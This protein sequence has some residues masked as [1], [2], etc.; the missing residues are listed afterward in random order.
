MVGVFD[1]IPR[2]DRFYPVWG[3]IGYPLN[4]K[5]QPSESYFSEGC[6]VGM[7]KNSAIAC[8]FT[9]RRLV[10]RRRHSSVESENLEITGFF[11]IKMSDAWCNTRH[12]SGCF[13]C[14][15]TTVFTGIRGYRLVIE[16][17][18][19]P[20]SRVHAIEHLWSKPHQPSHSGYNWFLHSHPRRRI[21]NT[22][23]Y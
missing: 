19:I 12:R 22:A 2:C 15:R 4:D 18:L 6:F 10:L 23:C 5:K 13:G 7:Y 9:C 14:L 1:A 11:F 21:C 20:S 8:D 16:R 17:N 3:K